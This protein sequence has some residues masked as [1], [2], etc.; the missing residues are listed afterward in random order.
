[1]ALWCAGILGAASG[2]RALLEPL[3]GDLVLFAPYYPATLVS[4]VLF[5]WP[6]GVAVAGGGAILANWLLAPGLFAPSPKGFAAAAVFACSAGVVVAMAQ[7]LRTALRKIEMGFEREAALNGELQHRVKNTLMI[8]QSVAAE[9]ARSAAS[10]DQFRIAY[11]ARLLALA[12]AHNIL[13]RTDWAI[14]PLAELVGGA[15]KPFPRVRMRGPPSDCAI[16]AD[17][18]VSLA[19]ALH[20][21]ATNAAKY[22]ALSTLGGWVE[23]SFRPGSEARKEVVIDWRECGGPPVTPPTRRGFGSRLLSR[24]NGVTPIK[25]SF[26]QQGLRCQIRVPMA[27]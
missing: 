18:C 9:T 3:L 8:V 7:W 10:M 19:L 4:T 14:C 13:S 20:E 16:P 6:A 11:E 17:T 5:G 21:L 23:V 2:V 12:E 24:L 1:V 27:T 26:D 15:L 22:G 25:L